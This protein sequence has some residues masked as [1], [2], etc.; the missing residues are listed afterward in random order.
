MTQTGALIFIVTV[1]CLLSVGCGRRTSVKVESALN[2][3][4]AYELLHDPI[5]QD[6]FRNELHEMIGSEGTYESVV[7][8]VRE[9]FDVDQQVLSLESRVVPERLRRH[10]G[11]KWRQFMILVAEK[12]DIYEDKVFLEF[13]FDEQGSFL[14][15]SYFMERGIF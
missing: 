14:S 6:A 3:Y 12:K 11:Q 13:G 15:T 9:N 4:T 10:F 1:V 8:L 2:S 7:A 5:K